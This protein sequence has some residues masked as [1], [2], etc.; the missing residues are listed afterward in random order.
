MRYKV[1]EYIEANA[2][3]SQTYYI[4]YDTKAVPQYFNSKEDPLNGL[5]WRFN[6]K[7]YADLV[8]MLIN[9]D[10]EDDV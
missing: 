3:Y 1:K 2:F 5:V 10:S 7:D 4:I 8:C 9:I 6:N